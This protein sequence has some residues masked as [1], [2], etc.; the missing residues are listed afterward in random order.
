MVFQ[1]LLASLLSS[2][3]DVS[4]CEFMLVGFLNPL[5]HLSNDEAVM[6]EKPSIPYSTLFYGCF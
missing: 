3:R 2:K 4:L 6:S 5:F 1:V